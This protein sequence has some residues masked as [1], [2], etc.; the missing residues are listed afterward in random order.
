MNT[1]QNPTVLRIKNMRELTEAEKADVKRLLAPGVATVLR[2]QAET[3][4]ATS[5]TGR[6]A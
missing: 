3:A 6:A 5:R 1:E 2:Q 4:N